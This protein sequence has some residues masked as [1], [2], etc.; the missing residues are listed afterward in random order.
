MSGRTFFPIEISA[1]LCTNTYY[2]S[3]L[4]STM[5]ILY[6]Y[7]FPIFGNIQKNKNAL[8]QVVWKIFRRFRLSKQT[9]NL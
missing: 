1:G 4:C 5:Y 6:L 8:K 3:V 7:I 9:K 2:L